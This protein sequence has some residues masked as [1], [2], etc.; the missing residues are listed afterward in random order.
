MQPSSRIR[1]LGFLACI[2]FIACGG[3]S[4]VDTSVDDTGTTSDDTSS[5]G[6]SNGGDS[7]SNG[8][9]RGSDAPKDTTS[10][11]DTTATDTTATDT[12]ATD[13]TT[14]DTTSGETTSDTPTETATC[15][16]VECAGFPTTFVDGCVF[17]DNCVGEMH[18]VDCCGAMRVIG[19]NHSAALT[20]CTAENGGV[21]STG[22]RASYPKPAPCSSSEIKA[23]DGA[24]TTDPT[25]VAVHCVAGSTGSFCKTFVCGTA[26]GPACPPFRRIGACGP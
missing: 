6:D 22:C 2:A 9:T 24:T 3:S 25:K 12:T 11:G 1:S 18:Q 17:D 26:G 5:G 14:S 13:T 23:D 20:F 21:G 15:A 10:G 16:G 8:D 7:T 4:N 19:M